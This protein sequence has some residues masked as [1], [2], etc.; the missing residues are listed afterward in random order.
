MRSRTRSVAFIGLAIALIAVS[1]WITIPLG[2]VPFTLQMLSITF[3][4]CI[5]SPK[6][7]IAAIYGYELL[8]AIGIPVFSGMRAGI[9]VLL[10]P[11]G[12][13]LLGY[14][15]GVPLAVGFLHI[16]RK[17]SIVS[18]NAWLKTLC[19]IAAGLIF[20]IVAYAFGTIQYMFVAN[21][22]L[23]VALATSVIPFI[24]PDIAKVAIAAVCSQTVLA[25]LGMANNAERSSDRA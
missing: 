19:C 14:L 5:L 1:A 7:A 8:G 20:T 23:E 25:A 22:G 9:G 16:M 13:F 2:P 12:G 11:T 15:I 10:G 4:I 21:V 18:S 17:S 6:E 24:V 3:V